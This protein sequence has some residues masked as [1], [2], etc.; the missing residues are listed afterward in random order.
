MPAT[1]MLKIT[2]RLLFQ[3]SMAPPLLLLSPSTCSLIRVFT[4]EPPP[5]A[6]HKSSIGYERQIPDSRNRAII[7]L[8][9]N[10]DFQHNFRVLNTNV[11]GKK[12]IMFAITF[13]M[14]IGR[15]FANIVCKK[16]DVNVN[17]VGIS[18]KR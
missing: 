9:T 18:K 10:D 11:D 3:P 13:I 6:I 8:I 16:A 5:T 1:S 7:S 4:H 12:N 17:I 2:R 15:R 14:G